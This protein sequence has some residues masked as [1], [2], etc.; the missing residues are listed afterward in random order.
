ML[1]LLLQVGVYAFEATVQHVGFEGF[2]V[3]FPGSEWRLL[4][5]LL[6]C[7]RGGPWK[8]LPG[9]RSLPPTTCAP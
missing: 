4:V 7:S 5:P 9:L 6:A 3:K 1:L 2:T 8:A